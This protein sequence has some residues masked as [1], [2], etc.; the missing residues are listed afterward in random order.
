M[1]RSSNFVE[2]FFIEGPEITLKESDGSYCQL[3]MKPKIDRKKT[4]ICKFSILETLRNYIMVGIVGNS[5]FLA[6][7]S[8][9]SGCAV[10]YFGV[11]NRYP[12]AKKEGNGFKAGDIVEMRIMLCDQIV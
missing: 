9:G 3:V 5:R 12:F 6:R 2:N 1:D 7:S 11:G 4:F 8:Y 10:A